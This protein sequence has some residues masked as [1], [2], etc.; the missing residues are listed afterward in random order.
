[1]NYTEEDMLTEFEYRC[2]V[3]EEYISKEIKRCEAARLLRLS[4]R[5]ITRLKNKY[6]SGGVTLLRHGL[7]GT[8]RPKMFDEEMSKVLLGYYTGSIALEKNDSTLD[9]SEYNISQFHVEVTCGSLKHLGYE[10]SYSTLYKGFKSLGIVSPKQKRANDRQTLKGANLNNTYDFGERLEI[11]ACE[12]DWFGDGKKYK[13]HVAYCRGYKAPIAIWFAKEETTLGYLNL[14]AEVFTKYGI[15][16]KVISDRR[17]T[18]VNLTKQKT[19]DEYMTMFNKSIIFKNNIDYYYSSNPDSKPGVES[20]NRTIEDQLPKEFKRL[21]IKNINEAN[22]YMK[23]YCEKRIAVSEKK[24]KKEIEIKKS[25]FKKK[26]SIKQINKEFIANESIV[27][28]DKHGFIPYLKKQYV[29]IRSGYATKYKPKDKITMCTNYLGDVFQKLEH[30]IVKVEQALS[31]KLPA[32]PKQQI[33]RFTKRTSPTSTITYKSEQ[34]VA[35]KTNGYHIEFKK[36]TEIEM[37]H[38]GDSLVCFFERNCY[39]LVNIKNYDKVSLLLPS[40]ECK[41]N[42]DFTIAYNKTRYVIVTK[43]KQLLIGKKSTTV[44]VCMYN[45]KLSCLVN[46]KRYNLIKVDDY[47]DKSQ[48]PKTNYIASKLLEKLKDSQEIFTIYNPSDLD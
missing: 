42:Y 7:K 8:T 34:Y 9:Y 46:G 30:S 14:F 6:L 20:C 4:K 23:E 36:G 21:G 26:L 11:D 33:I 39:K 5:Q 48:L 25:L 15:P 24:Y 40:Q 1:M 27:S 10:L 31:P 43:E 41:L 28:V 38:N 16:Q 35:V 45:Y 22:Q 32:T 47:Q 3:I 18:F 29:A 44:S 2:Y 17:G 13:A 12:F 19:D 37:E